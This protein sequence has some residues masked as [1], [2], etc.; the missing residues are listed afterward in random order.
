MIFGTLPPDPVVVVVDGTSYHY[1]DGVFFVRVAPGS[2]GP[3]TFQVVA[4][5]VGAVIG[6]LPADADR[7]IVD[8]A[9]Y[10]RLHGTWFRPH[11][12]G[13]QVVVPL[14]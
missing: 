8:G 13:F 7:T 3:V 4:A 6:V 10:Y 12:S 1:A 2:F 5:P 14:F 11:S 9:V